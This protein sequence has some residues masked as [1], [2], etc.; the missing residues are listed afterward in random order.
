M[1]PLFV[2][3]DP[4][5]GDYTVEAKV[6][7]LA[8]DD[9][10]GLAFRYATNR[11]YYLFALTG[12]K[13]ARLAVRLP[14][15]TTLRVAEFRELGRAPFPYDTE[16]YYHLKVENDGPRIR[17]YVDGRLLIEATDGEI[18]RGKAGLVANIPA[19]YQAFRVSA[20]AAGARRPS[21]HAWRRGTRSWRGSA[22]P[23]RG[24]ASGRSSTRPASEPGA[25]CASATSTETASLDMLIAQNIP[26]VQRRRLRPHQRADRG[27]AGRQGA[28]AVGPA[29]PRQRRS[30]PTTRPSRSTT[31]TATGANEV[32]LVRDFKLQVLDGRTGAV[33]RSASGC[34]RCPRTRGR[35]PTSSTAATRSSSRASPEPGR[36]DI[37][38]KDRYR[39]FW[40]Y[41][42]DLRLLWQG[43][44]D[45]G[46]YPY[47]FDADGDGLDELFIGHSLWDRTGRR[48]WSHDGKLKDHVD[49]LAVGNFSA[50]PRRR[51]ASTG[52][53]ATRRS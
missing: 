38:L 21:T 47:P 2:T 36:R 6:R 35:A 46:H 24:R 26:R 23:I 39:N 27:H 44:D 31:W 37:V 15:E 40:A 43:A 50:D 30:S 49:A 7:P 13:E 11:H 42:A 12:G 18:L 22:P 16:A 1:S 4:E 28:L 19:R 45:T 33:K 34:R 32:V 20:C 14:L 51:R 8:L 10:A 41:S 52:R 9:L 48:L 17:A 25:T 53:R 5:W 29:R 3:G